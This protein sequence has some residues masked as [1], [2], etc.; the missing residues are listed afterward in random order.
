MPADADC[1]HRGQHPF[2][3]TRCSACRTCARADRD[4]QRRP[5]SFSY[6]EAYAH[7]HT[8]TLSYRS[9]FR[10]GYSYR[11]A[12]VHPDAHSHP[13]WAAGNYRDH[14][15]RGHQHRRDLGCHRSVA[16]LVQRRRAESRACHRPRACSRSGSGA[17]GQCAGCQLAGHRPSPLSAV[18]GCPD[19]GTASDSN[20]HAHLLP[21]CRWLLS[22]VRQPVS[23]KRVAGW[24]GAGVGRAGGLPAQ[25]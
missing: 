12:A 7:T 15:Y 9:Q 11:D 20:P 13:R 25:R 3:I 18:P 10:I 2:P 19:R 17:R 1:A 22:H 21:A 23:A 16:G 4:H 6:A 8:Q 24:T 14:A 5:T